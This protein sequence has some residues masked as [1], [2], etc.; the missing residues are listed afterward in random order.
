MSLDDDVH[1]VRHHL[2]RAN[3]VPEPGRTSDEFLTPLPVK[4]RGRPRVVAAVALAAVAAVVAALVLVRPTSRHDSVKPV[5]AAYTVTQQA[6][7][8]QAAVTVTAG[9]TTVTAEGVGNL[10]TGEANGT[11][12]LPIPFGQVP[13]VSTGQVIYAQV[14]ANLRTFT[15]GKPWVRLATA[16]LADMENAFL[17]NLGLKQPFDPTNILGYLKSISGNVTVV[18]HDTLRGADTTHYR[19]TI[20]VAKTAVPSD[21]WI[22][23]A[24]RLR[25]LQMSFTS[26]VAAT[27]VFELWNFGTAV[28]ATPP[29]SGQVADP[30]KILSTLLGGD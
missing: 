17:G 2:G 21:L 27:A 22:D 5:L 14:P 16:N 4:R 26:P 3:P 11:V 18:G 23:S 28:N 12:K 24:G 10:T 8:A 20:D 9:S 6:S 13:F 29:A 7:T 19:A 30:P 1:A 15:G 25:K